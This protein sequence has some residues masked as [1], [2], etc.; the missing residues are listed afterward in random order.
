MRLKKKERERKLEEDSEGD[1]VY[2]YVG[3]AGKQ[4]Q[5]QEKGSEL[6][7]NCELFEFRFSCI[8]FAV[9]VGS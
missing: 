6:L 2:T 9:L 8:V 1:L 5:H 4:Q 3:M 7:R